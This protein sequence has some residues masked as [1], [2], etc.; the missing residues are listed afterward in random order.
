LKVEW[1][2]CVREEEGS[3]GEGMEESD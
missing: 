1:A 3:S 2:A